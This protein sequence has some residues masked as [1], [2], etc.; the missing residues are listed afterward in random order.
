M[1]QERVIQ[2]F[3]GQY[4]KVEQMLAHL[5]AT[6]DQW[7]DHLQTNIAELSQQSLEVLRGHQEENC[8]TAFSGFTQEIDQLLRL[9]AQNAKRFEQLFEVD[10]RWEFLAHFM[11][12]KQGKIRSKYTKAQYIFPKSMI[13]H[14]V[15]AKHLQQEALTIAQKISDY[16]Q[17]N[18]EAL[19]AL[20]QMFLRPHKQSKQEVA[21]LSDLTTILSE[22]S[23]AL[24]N[25]FQL[26][27]KQDFTQIALS[28]VHALQSDPVLQDFCKA[29]IHHI[30]L[31]EFQ[32]TSSMQYQMAQALVE[33][34]PTQEHITIFAV[35]DPMQ[36]IYRFRQADV[37][38]FIKTQNEPIAHIKP[39]P[40]HLACNFR[41]STV[42]IEAI[43]DHFAHIFPQD[44][45]LLHA[46][47][48][49][50]KAEPN[51]P[52]PN[53]AGI[54][55]GMSLIQALWHKPCVLLISYNPFISSHHK[56]ALVFWHKQVS[57]QSINYST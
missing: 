19:D 53:Q 4:Q 56:L 41:S 18:P 33:C 43:N 2:A 7:L 55:L 5:L 42:M 3:G 10:N 37:R 35:G 50:R 46:A 22:L 49:Y 51:K 39:E 31:D 25:H 40:L 20:M 12:T 28:T 45:D 13:D 1:P 15:N 32:D 24:V 52:S 30:L 36:S 23:I 16:L 38:L 21:F 29:H 47:I 26:I 6:H 48:Q 8:H 57:S 27:D 54:Y 44:D 11:L 14:D 9:L 34:W 17:Q